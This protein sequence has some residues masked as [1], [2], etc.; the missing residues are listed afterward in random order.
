MNKDLMNGQEE[1]DLLKLLQAL[2]KKAW[3]IVLAAII[4]G[5][6]FL[7]YTIFFVTPL[8]T[9]S[10]LLYVNNSTIDVGST[11]LNITSSDIYASN[12]L[13]DVFSVILKSR[14][15]LNEAI[16]EG[17]LPYTYEQLVTKVSGG[18]EGD[19]PVFKITVV[20][21][22]PDMAAHIANTLVEVITDNISNIVEGSSVKI[23]DDAVSPRK[24]SSPSYIR[25]T[26]IG[27]MAGFVLVCGFIVL[28][29]L[30]DTTIREEEYLLDKYKDIP[31]LAT[32]PN[33]SADSRGGYYGYGRSYASA[34]EKAKRTNEER[35][36]QENLERKAQAQAQQRPG[37]MNDDQISGS[38]FVTG[39]GGESEGK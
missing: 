4:G 26:A 13:V 24:A 8:Y 6:A 30:M 29:S 38:P 2:W 7:L 19:T 10:A 17:R 36:R 11:K 3:L 23:V 1:I 39:P 18:A 25:N 15:T 12:S 32:V 33:L 31:L 14:N 5:A 9:S 22:D 27:M 28:R 35:H 20:D 21:A 37:S 34:A 16:D